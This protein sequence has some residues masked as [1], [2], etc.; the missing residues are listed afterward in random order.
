VEEIV[1]A[2]VIYWKG[3]Q[4]T[5]ND[6]I[7]TINKKR[8][9]LYENIV[10]GQPQEFSCCY[11]LS[12]CHLVHMF[13]NPTSIVR[14]I[15]IYKIWSIQM[16]IKT[17]IKAYRALKDLTQAELAAIVG[18]RRETINVLEAYNLHMTL[19][20][21]LMCPSMIFLSLIM[22]IIHMKH[23]Y[24]AKKPFFEECFISSPFYL[25]FDK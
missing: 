19:R 24:Y 25:Q 17:R 20:G 12:S 21:H 2:L 11:L 23:R 8:E 13:S 14:E 9:D 1:D 3:R 6:R 5:Y 18:V 22:T 16:A 10:T 7:Y 4:L 15:L